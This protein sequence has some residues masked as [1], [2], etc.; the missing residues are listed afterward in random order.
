M[1]ACSWTACRNAVGCDGRSRPSEDHGGVTNRASHPI[2]LRRHCTGGKDVGT[3]QDRA[4][5]LGGCV[6][7]LR[8][9]AFSGGLRGSSFVVGRALPAD[10]CRQP[11]DR[12]QHGRPPAR[13]RPAGQ[14]LVYLELL[15]GCLC[16]HGE[17]P[18]GSEKSIHAAIGPVRLERVSVGPA[19]E[20]DMGLPTTRRPGGT[21]PRAVHNR[22]DARPQR[23]PDR[24]VSHR[25]R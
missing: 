4:G 2:S 7:G 12:H 5:R 24:R 20:P 21:R 11:K 18:S 10:L 19:N 6:A 3:P 25:N 16:H 13:N 23:R 17:R 8:S 14:L 9:M 22:L 15:D 1:R